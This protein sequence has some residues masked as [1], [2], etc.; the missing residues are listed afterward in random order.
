MTD[1]QY[2]KDATPSL[3]ARQQFGRTLRLWRLR[4]GW[5]QD[6][7]HEWGKAAGFP[8]VTDAVWNKLE[9]GTVVG[10]K[11]VTFNQLGLANDR[12]ARQDWGTIRNRKLRDRVIVQEPI[13][14]QDSTPWTAVD[15]F[16]HFCGQKSAPPWADADRAWAISPEAAE[17]LG[18]Q[19]RE[20][21]IEFAE[22]N[23]LDRHEAWSQVLQHCNGMSQEQVD[24]FRKVLAG[25]H[26]WKPEELAAMTD[27]CGRN[28]TIEALQTWCDSDQLCKEFRDMCP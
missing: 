11:P 2:E 8:V 13:C 7:L 22:A 3:E 26:T 10:P 18:H 1:Y 25:H 20:I 12:I 4:A 19:Q 21:F 14:N 28:K 15:F 5:N 27:G 23:F 6:T 24:Q 16:A 17:K 9:N